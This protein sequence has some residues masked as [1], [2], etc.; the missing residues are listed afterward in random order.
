[1]PAGWRFRSWEDLSWEVRILKEFGNEVFLLGPYTVQDGC[2]HFQ[3]G[4]DSIL[5]FGSRADA[6]SSKQLSLQCSAK[7]V[8]IWLTLSFILAVAYLYFG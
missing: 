2:V 4:S 7:W 3:L 1:L 6:L 8:V 5:W